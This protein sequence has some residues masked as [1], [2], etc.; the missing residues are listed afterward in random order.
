MENFDQTFESFSF[1]EGISLN[2]DILE[3]GLINN[4]VLIV[5]L[6]I[7]LS[8][9]LGPALKTRKEKIEN[10][11]KQATFRVKEANKRLEE[12]ERQ[13][14]LANVLISEIKIETLTTKKNL[15]KTSANQVKSELVIYLD[16]ALATFTSKER[17]IVDEIRQQ[18]ISLV[19]QKLVNYAQETFSKKDLAVKFIKDTMSKLRE[20]EGENVL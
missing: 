15:L 8:D 17:Q 16:R 3:T 13:L 5:I 9:L 11:L 1:L 6:Y 20:L 4:L 18:I 19:L 12:A 10:D 2:S 7:F 14:S